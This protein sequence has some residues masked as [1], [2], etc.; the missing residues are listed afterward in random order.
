MSIS[1]NILIS[2]VFAAIC[3]SNTMA[4]SKQSAVLEFNDSQFYNQLK[5]YK[6]AVVSFYAPWCHYSQDL[7]PELD[8]SAKYVATLPDAKVIKV[9]CWTTSRA[10]CDAQVFSKN[11][12]N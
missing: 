11:T 1:R 5:N 9:D 7:L 10:T 12:S 8:T 4:A 3:F 6:V 2:F